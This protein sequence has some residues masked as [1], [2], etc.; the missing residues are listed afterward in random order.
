M[1]T[2]N[3]VTLA[4]L[5]G[6]GAG[7][8]LAFTTNAMCAYEEQTHKPFTAVTEVLNGRDDIHIS[9]QVLRTILWAG[10][11]EFHEG[12][13]MKEAGQVLDAVGF[14]TVGRSIGEAIRLAFPEEKKATGGKAPAGNGA[15]PV[16][17][18]ASTG[19]S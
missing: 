18:A 8:K 13:T 19:P 5:D 3:Y 16:G 6:Q 10:L 4:P 17:T 1:T 15:P 2:K 14:Q 7:W 12:T 9:V 11:Q